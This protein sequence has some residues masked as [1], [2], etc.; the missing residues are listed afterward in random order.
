MRKE[1]IGMARVESSFDLDLRPEQAWRVVGDLSDVAS[2]VPG[3]VTAHL[4]GDL[5]VCRTADGQEIQER[6]SSVE[7]E[8]MAYSY[9]H[10]VT[11]APIRDSWGILRVRPNGRGC[12][13][14]W[15]AA[16]EPADPARADQITAMMRANVADALESLRRRIET[17]SDSDPA[18]PR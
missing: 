14:E 4:V 2:W 12:A 3:V 6:L 18:L 7:G 10:L 8:R 17:V 11:P 16:F 15:Y 13:V 9:E 1:L 5:R